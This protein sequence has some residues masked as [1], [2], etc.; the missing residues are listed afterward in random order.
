MCYP[1]MVS[2]IHRIEVEEVSR[3]FGA[4]LALHRVS[5]NFEAGTVTFLEGPNGAGKST[6]LAVIGTVLRLT[7]GSIRYLPL[8]SDL[9]AARGQIGWVAHESHC[10]LELTGRENVELYALLH[11]IH[12]GPAWREVRGR[13]RAEAFGDRRVGTLSRGQRQRIAIARVLVAKPSVLLLDEPWTGLD[14]ESSACLFQVLREE[15]ERGA[16]IIVASHSTEWADG[17]DARRLVLE[18]GRVKASP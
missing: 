1:K 9:Q 7:S 5:A 17:L 3:R 4:T 10:Y 18:A 8:G 11:G 6:L 16:L 15:K 13:V 2:G 12:P 14:S